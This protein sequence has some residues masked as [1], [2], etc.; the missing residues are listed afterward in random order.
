MMD[1][2][3]I[4]VLVCLATF[5]SGADHHPK[6][7]EDQTEEAYDSG[8]IRN[9]R[10]PEARNRAMKYQ[11]PNFNFES[12]QQQDRLRNR[13]AQQQAVDSRSNLYSRGP[14]GY[15]SGPSPEARYLRN[16]PQKEVAEEWT[17][18]QPKISKQIS[19]R[20]PKVQTLESNKSKDSIIKGNVFGDLEVAGSETVIRKH[21]TDRQD[22]PL[23]VDG[24]IVYV[25]P[26]L[27][28]DILGQS[29][30]NSKSLGETSK[31]EFNALNDLV[32]KNPNIQLEGLKRLLQEE[33][34]YTP[35]FPVI[36]GPQPFKPKDHTPIMENTVDIPNPKSRPNIKVNHEEPP[37]IVK[38][39]LQQSQ[40]VSQNSLESIQK[41]LDAASNIEAQRILEKANNEA[42]AHVDAQHNAIAKAQQ[43]ILEKFKSSLNNDSP[44]AL[45]LVQETLPN[46]KHNQG[47]F[48]PTPIPDYEE[49]HNVKLQY[50]PKF[51][52]ALPSPSASEVGS[53]I[54]HNLNKEFLI[55]AQQ[56]VSS[57]HQTKPL[58]IPNKGKPV[59]QYPPKDVQSYAP[60]HLHQAAA[61]IQAEKALFSQVQAQNNAIL[62]GYK[63]GHN[64]SGPRKFPNVKQVI[65][66]EPSVADTY[67]KIIFDQQGEKKGN[68]YK[69][70][71]GHPDGDDDLQY[72]ARYAFGYRIK[73]AKAG[74]DFGHQE[75]RNGKSAEGSYFVLL[76]DGRK[77]KVEYWADT[78]GY[79]AKVSYE[80]VGHHK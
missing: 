7:H 31:L 61:Q 17:P 23:N 54:T 14:S 45:P 25:H 33:A 21:A 68:I 11:P 58:F 32:G 3:T 30:K 49:A 20:K 10:N 42:Q 43:A 48:F 8:S 78:T 41:Q 60:N 67:Q 63:S 6:V 57:Q 28:K 72:A 64:L 44:Q 66:E 70:S 34:Q 1:P 16:N 35:T 65:Q 75:K 22:Q 12:A 69:K 51:S 2:K 24:E 37:P 38:S 15:P 55:P 59:H 74:N 50:A 80:H 79:H 26:S 46:Y 29:S 77:Q 53:E 52:T 56:S 73:D 71:V 62:N 18:F 36:Q 40:T 9:V 4:I 76:P 13:Y 5:T 39:L 47:P 27:L 19:E